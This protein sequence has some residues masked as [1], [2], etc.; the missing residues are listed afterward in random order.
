MDEYFLR[1]MLFIF[2]YVL[3]EDII[4]FKIFFSKLPLPNLNNVRL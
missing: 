4:R 3:G 1:N 2:F